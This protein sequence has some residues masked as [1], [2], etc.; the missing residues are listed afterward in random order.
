MKRRSWER[1][2]CYKRAATVA[3][4][5]SLGGTTADLRYDHARGFFACSEELAQWAAPKPG[6]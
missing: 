1:F 2:E 6:E 3:E 4:F 5:F